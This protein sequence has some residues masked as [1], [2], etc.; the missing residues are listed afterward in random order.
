MIPATFRAKA[1]NPP[2]S[3]PPVAPAASAPI[4]AAAQR[5]AALPAA[6]RHAWLAGHLGA[7]RAG[8]FPLARLP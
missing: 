2:G 4:A 6:A 8:R 1:A 3:A 7:L 5:F